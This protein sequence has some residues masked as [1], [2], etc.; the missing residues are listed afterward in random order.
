[1][2]VIRSHLATPPP[3]K[4]SRA[5]TGSCC[6]A[7]DSLRSTQRRRLPATGRIPIRRDETRPR[8]SGGSCTNEP[9][10]S[11]A[12]PKQPPTCSTRWLTP[13]SAAASGPCLAD[14]PPAFAAFRTHE[15]RP[16]VTM[17]FPTLPNPATTMLRLPK[18]VRNGRCI[19]SCWWSCCGK[20]RRVSAINGKYFGEELPLLPI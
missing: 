18:T 2:G 12:S 20:L 13:Y 17:I 3:T 16:T 15:V 8:A 14:A 19:D 7:G 9:Q 10:D 6:F 11:E 1:V 4:R 5:Q